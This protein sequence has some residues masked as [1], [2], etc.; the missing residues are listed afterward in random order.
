[1]K[2]YTTINPLFS[3]LNESTCHDKPN[4]AQLN[5]EQS[6]TETTHAVVNKDRFYQN[7]TKQIN[8]AKEA[9]K[10][11]NNFKNIIGN[12][13]TKIQS[14]KQQKKYDEVTRTKSN[15]SLRFSCVPG[16]S[17]D[18]PHS[19]PVNSNIRETVEKE[20]DTGVRFLTVAERIKKLESD[21]PFTP[22]NKSDKFEKNTVSKI[23]H[24]TASFQNLASDIADKVQ[25][26]AKH[27][28]LE[29]SPGNGEYS[30]LK[31]LINSQSNLFSASSERLDKI[32]E[33]F[34]KV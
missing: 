3:I 23:P 27:Q 26:R 33:N 19:L 6:S 10:S 16:K 9:L 11:G 7:D 12:F 25:V 14:T 28:D 18:A 1:M 30:E 32:E 8:S 21:F 2:C 13:E 20:S 31:A 24:S 29:I 22:V 34:E 17:F 5:K 4:E 15:S